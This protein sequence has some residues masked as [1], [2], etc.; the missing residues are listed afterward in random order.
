VVITN[1]TATGK[2]FDLLYGDRRVLRRA[3]LNREH[4]AR[5]VEQNEALYRV[6][7]DRTDSAAG[8]ADVLESASFR[9]RI[10]H[11]LQLKFDERIT[12]TDGL[13]ICRV[14]RR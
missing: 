3:R 9:R 12:P 1:W 13:H 4:V 10:G 5:L 2:F 8:R 14:E 11:P 6:F 7:L